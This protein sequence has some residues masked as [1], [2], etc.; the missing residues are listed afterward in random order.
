MGKVALLQIKLHQNK[1]AYNL[2]DSI[3]GH[4]VITL[5]HEIKLK[6]IKIRLY[7]CAYTHTKSKNRSV[8]ERESDDTYEFETYC[9]QSITIFRGGK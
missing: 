4:V 3:I 6:Y 8:I 2:G 5:S 1:L 7:G 9:D